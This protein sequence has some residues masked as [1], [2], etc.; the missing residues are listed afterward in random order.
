M[1]KHT[2]IVKHIVYTYTKYYKHTGTILVGLV[3]F[4]GLMG[5][6][7]LGW[8][9]GWLVNRSSYAVRSNLQTVSNTF[10]A[11]SLPVIHPDD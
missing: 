7:L 6:W 8:L 10:A 3:W 1:N 9:V 2:G 5:D 4:G 11:W